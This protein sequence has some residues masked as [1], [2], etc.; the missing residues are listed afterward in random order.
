MDEVTTLS[1][2]ARRLNRNKHT[3]FYHF[4][5]E[6]IPAKRVGGVWFV[7]VGDV[8]NACRAYKRNT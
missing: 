4:R 7:R 2:A 6:R 8:E 5:K 1:E 3:V